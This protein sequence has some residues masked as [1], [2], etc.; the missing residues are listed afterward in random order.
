MEGQILLF[1]FFGLHN[2]DHWVMI[3]LFL[4]IEEAVVCLALLCFKLILTTIISMKEKDGT[5]IRKDIIFASGYSAFSVFFLTTLMLGLFF[6]GYYTTGLIDIITLLNIAVIPTMVAVEF[7]YA[8]VK[9]GKTWALSK[10]ACLTLMNNILPFIICVNLIYGAYLMHTPW[11]LLEPK[12]CLKDE[13]ARQYQ[14]LKEFD[15]INRMGFSSLPLSVGVCEGTSDLGL[16]DDCYG[17]LAGKN[18]SM[19]LCERIREESKRQMCKSNVVLSLGDVKGC[20]TLTRGPWRNYCLRYLAKQLNETS[21]CDMM[22]ADESRAV[23]NEMTWCLHDV[24]ENARNKS[25]CASLAER[26]LIRQCEASVEWRI[27]DDMKTHK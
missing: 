21:I 14:C 22:A 4:L 27:K 11:F 19:N 25:L 1:N 12:D 23:E 26:E 6:G 20:E 5:S 10:T 18:A 16:K 3:L 2:M 24:A 9:W 15:K 8:Y 13:P 7:L 17:D